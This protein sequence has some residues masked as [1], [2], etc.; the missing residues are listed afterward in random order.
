MLV[1][2]AGALGRYWLIGRMADWMRHAFPWGTLTV[3]VVGCFL[4]GAVVELSAL[5]WTPTPEMRAFLSVGL[6]GAFTTFSAFS[7]EV[8]LMAERGQW[9]MAALYVAGSVLLAVGG[10]FAGLHLFRAILV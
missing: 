10:L 5:A 7:V 4:L 8:Y 3:N 1:A 2:V 6:L 9:E